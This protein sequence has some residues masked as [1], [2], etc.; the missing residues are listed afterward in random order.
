MSQQEPEPLHTLEQALQTAPEPKNPENAFISAQ[1]AFMVHD[2]A[3]TTR[4]STGR[5][6]YAPLRPVPQNGVKREIHTLEDILPLLPK[7]KRC[8]RKKKVLGKHWKDKL[9]HA[10]QLFLMHQRTC[11]DTRGRPYAPLLLLA[12][13]PAAA[14]DTP[15]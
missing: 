4:Q 14:P 11:D 5:K 8:R 15:A 2:R 10:T 7:R 13:P 12:T 9:V 3:E 1:Q 6:P